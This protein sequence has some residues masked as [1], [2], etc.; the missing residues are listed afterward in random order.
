LYTQKQG[1]EKLGPTV[2]EANAEEDEQARAAS[3]EENNA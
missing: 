3:S 2:L 1:P